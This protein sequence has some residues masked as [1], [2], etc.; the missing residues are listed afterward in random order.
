MCCVK[1]NKAFKKASET[2]NFVKA[3]AADPLRQIQLYGY[4]IV[5]NPTIIFL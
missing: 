1:G 5:F 3:K 2:L 4:V